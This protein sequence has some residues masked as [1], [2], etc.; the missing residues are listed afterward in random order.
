MPQTTQNDMHRPFH[1]DVAEITAWN[2]PTLHN[3]EKK[4][5]HNWCTVDMA[6]YFGLTEQ[7]AQLQKTA[8]EEFLPG[9]WELKKK[10]PESAVYN[11]CVL[12]WPQE[13]KFSP[14][15]IG[16]MIPDPVGTHQRK[17]ARKEESIITLLIH[18]IS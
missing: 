9:E 8:D 16:W 14:P 15:S 4:F 3:I 7:P 10:R 11:D 13:S 2:Y 6:D 5:C 12:I 18:I 1:F 17:P